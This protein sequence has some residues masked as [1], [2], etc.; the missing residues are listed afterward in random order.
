VYDLD[1]LDARTLMDI[2]ATHPFVVHRR[3]VMKNPYYRPPVDMLESMLLGQHHHH[4]R[5][6]VGEQQ[7]Q[8]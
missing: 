2:L 6:P 8:A 7:I 3:E 5:Q 4:G 1:R